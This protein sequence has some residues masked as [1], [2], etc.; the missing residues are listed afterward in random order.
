MKRISVSMPL[1]GL[2]PFLL[3]LSLRNQNQLIVSMPLIGLIP[4]LLT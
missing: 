1:I 3:F 2:I 4:F